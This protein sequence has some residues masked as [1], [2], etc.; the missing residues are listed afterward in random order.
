ME[1]ANLDRSGSGDPLDQLLRE[2]RPRIADDGFST[3]VMAAVDARRRFA[4]LRF[5][6]MVAGGALG[7]AIAAAAGAFGPG[8]THVSADLQRNFSDLAAVAAKPSVIIAAIV[9][10]AALV[11]VFRR[12]ARDP[13]AR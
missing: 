1:S 7:F 8:A 13:A 2:A 4:R 9:I 10:A 3:H 11:Y 12:N 5:C 6:L